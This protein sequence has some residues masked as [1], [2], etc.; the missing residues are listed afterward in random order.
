MRARSW[1][2]RREIHPIAG[3]GVAGPKTEQ[4]RLRGENTPETCW[5]NSEAVLFGSRNEKSNGRHGG[6]CSKA[7]IT[8]WGSPVR[9]RQGQTCRSY[10]R[11][12]RQGSPRRCR[13]ASQRCKSSKADSAGRVGRCRYGNGPASA[14]Y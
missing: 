8:G 7:A 13:P 10:Y 1:H 2:L 14:Q 4:R 9:D 12:Q 6:T 11:A 5:A 3:T